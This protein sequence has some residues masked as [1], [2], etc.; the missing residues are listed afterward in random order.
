MAP[1]HKGLSLGVGALGLVG[2]AAH[3]WGWWAIASTPGCD[4][5]VRP[6]FQT[7]IALAL[8][9]SAG[10]AFAL[11]RKTETPLWKAWLAV[12]APFGLLNVLLAVGLTTCFL[13]RE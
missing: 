9:P 7:C 10:I 13:A 3:A 8:F 1:S 4:D 6:F 11:A 2:A 12:A 5:P